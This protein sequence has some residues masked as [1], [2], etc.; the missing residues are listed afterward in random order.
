MAGNNGNAPTVSTRVEMMTGFLDA[1]YIDRK[2]EDQRNHSQ[3]EDLKVTVLK[4]LKR[5]PVTL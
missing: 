5:R 1:E 2:I 4:I 3:V